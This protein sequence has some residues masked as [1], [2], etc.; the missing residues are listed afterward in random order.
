MGVPKRIPS[1]SSQLESK[2][3]ELGGNK[4]IHRCKLSKA[5][6]PAH[7]MQ[8]GAS[9]D[10]CAC[11]THVIPK[12][13]A[14]SCYVCC[15]NSQANALFC[16]VLVANNGMAAVKF[17]RSVQDWAYKSFGHEHAV[18][19]VAMATPE[20]MRV[21]AEHIKMADQF[22]EVPGGSNNNNYANVRLIV[23]TAEKANVDAVW[24]G[25]SV[26]FHTLL[27]VL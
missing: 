24:P 25:W 4:N 11:R 19:I 27:H 12:H 26:H 6:M 9:F 22:V 7:D 14:L 10:T 20:D 13:E 15:Y 21:D 3:F 5:P 23:Q 16:S 1:L 2:V 8:C 18:A 17:I